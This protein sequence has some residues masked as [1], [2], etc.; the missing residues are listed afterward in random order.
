[1]YGRTVRI[2]FVDKLFY[3][4]DFNEFEGSFDKPFMADVS[5]LITPCPDAITVEITSIARDPDRRELE[6]FLKTEARHNLQVFMR[7]HYVDSL[8]NGSEA[9]P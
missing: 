7:Q 3:P 4:E 8:Q 6:S 1:M 2:T 9:V 5:A